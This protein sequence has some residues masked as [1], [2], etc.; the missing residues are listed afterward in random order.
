MPN[1]GALR[2]SV[3]FLA[4]VISE[5]AR[6]HPFSEKP[7]VCG[8]LGALNRVPENRN[9]VRFLGRGGAERTCEHCPKGQCEKA[10]DRSDEKAR[11][12]HAQLIIERVIS[13]VFAFA[14][15]N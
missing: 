1:R 4:R 13:V 9:E 15:S 11:F 7:Q 2:K 6:I 5:I 12:C 10:A 8:K 3:I 14:N